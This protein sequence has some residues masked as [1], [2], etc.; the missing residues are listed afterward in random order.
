LTGEKIAGSETRRYTGRAAPFA[1]GKFRVSR[2]MRERRDDLE[3]PEIKTHRAM[4]GCTCIILHTDEG[5]QQTDLDK[6][7]RETKK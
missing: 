2:R 1:A 3:G 6:L 4:V 7:S 5:V